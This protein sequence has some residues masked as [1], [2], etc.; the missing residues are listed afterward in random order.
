[1]DTTGTVTLEVR[2][3]QDAAGVD[4]VTFDVTPAMVLAGFHVSAPPSTP[5]V[6]ASVATD[7]GPSIK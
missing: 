1:M 3:P 5:A 6:V 2:D 7:K 4:S